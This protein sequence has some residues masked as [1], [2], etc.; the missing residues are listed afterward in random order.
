MRLASILVMSLCCAAVVQ[1]PLTGR[2]TDHSGQPLVDVR[3][4]SWPWEE[5]RTDNLG[6]FKMS[7]PARMIRFSKDGHQP[8]TIATGV[9]TATVVLRPATVVSWKPPVCPP[10]VSERFGEAM[11][12]ATPRGA[13]LE[14]G[15][16][17]DFRTVSIRYGGATLLFGTGPHWTYGLPNP[18]TLGAMIT[19]R[20]RDVQT[21]WGFPAAE[22][23][24]R[25]AD[26][27]QWRQL[28]ILGESI[29]YDR[30]NA[31]AAA[32]FDAVIDSLCFEVAAPPN[33][34]LQP[35]AAVRP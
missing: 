5:V 7:R 22:Y 32:Y 23:H 19:V 28:L 34:R 27:T 2:V 31:K 18:D 17:V 9:I 12:F 6:Q 11:L 15:A 3:V 4:M 30:A 24:G 20:E 13:R 8:L 10:S 35:T 33:R 21:P 1:P 14:E 29:G 26:G 16:D 25:R